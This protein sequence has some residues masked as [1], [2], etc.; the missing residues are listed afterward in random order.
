M[1]ILRAIPLVLVLLGGIALAACDASRDR[2]TGLSGPPPVTSVIVLAPEH[3]AAVKADSAAFIVI[4]AT[5]M[6]TAVEFVLTWT[7]S[8]ATI[9]AQRVEFDVA[10]EEVEETFEVRIPALE[11]GSYLR[12]QGVAEDF[13]GQRHLSQPVVVVVV[14]CEMS[15][16]ACR[17]L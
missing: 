16:L 1:R 8:S 12:I 10:Q 3:E 6:V 17:E 9:D 5:G 14:D 4:Q 15:P 13:I 11:T 2:P 7:V